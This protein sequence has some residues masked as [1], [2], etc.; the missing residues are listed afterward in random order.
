MTNLLVW[1]GL[2]R[3]QV[4]WEVYDLKSRNTYHIN[5]GLFIFKEP[6]TKP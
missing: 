3:S 6:K 2:L 1:S 4:R 5:I